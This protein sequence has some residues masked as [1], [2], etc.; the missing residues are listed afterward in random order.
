MP[1]PSNVTSKTAA[2]RSMNGG[3]PS[4]QK[5]DCIDGDSM[6]TSDD[7]YVTEVPLA[8]TPLNL[9]IF[10]SHGSMNFH[11]CQLASEWKLLLY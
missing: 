5:R 4:T 3:E 7:S 2:K 11:P 1:S 10:T 6:A 9:V 8:I